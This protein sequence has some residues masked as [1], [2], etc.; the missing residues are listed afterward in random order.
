MVCTSAISIFTVKQGTL[1]ST[2]NI[3]WGMLS[4]VS[5][6]VSLT[7]FILLQ[8]YEVIDEDKAY[9]LDGQVNAR[10]LGCCFGPLFIFGFYC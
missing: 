5:F 9:S 1:F 4:V 10:I 7:N 6:I 2:K 8:G 3:K